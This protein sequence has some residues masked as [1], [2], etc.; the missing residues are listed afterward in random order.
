M[1]FVN[2]DTARGPENKQQM[3]CDNEISSHHLKLLKVIYSPIIRKTL[4]LSNKSRIK[5]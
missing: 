5:S 2:Y 4:T 1:Q 3:W